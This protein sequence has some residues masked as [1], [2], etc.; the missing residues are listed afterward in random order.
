MIMA[1]SK[2]VFITKLLGNKLKSISSIEFADAMVGMMYS[3]PILALILFLTASLS[4]NNEYFGSNL[5]SFSEFSPNT[6]TGSL[7]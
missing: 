3:L 4:D 6:E 1:T 2:F 5:A 7:N